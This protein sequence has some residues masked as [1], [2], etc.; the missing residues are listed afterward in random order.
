MGN[1]IANIHERESTS[2]RYLVACSIVLLPQD[3]GSYM[4]TLGVTARMISTITS[5][6]IS[7][8]LIESHYLSLLYLRQAVYSAKHS[9]SSR[10]ADGYKRARAWVGRRFSVPV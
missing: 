5:D 1:K 3:H 4:A 10:V 6:D 7:F 9:T 2:T 8:D